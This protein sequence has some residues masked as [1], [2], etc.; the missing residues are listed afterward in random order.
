MTFYVIARF[1][2]AAHNCMP[3]CKVWDLL[4]IKSYTATVS[5]V[6]SL[7]PEKSNSLNIV[8]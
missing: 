3:N 8:Q 5:N 2:A 1:P 7:C 4:Y 6:S